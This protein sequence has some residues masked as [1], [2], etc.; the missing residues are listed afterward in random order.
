MVLHEFATNAV[1]YGALS[2]PEGFVRI[3]GQVVDGSLELKWEE[4]NGPHLSGSP[5]HEGFGGML[6][7]RIVKGQF[8]G[9][10][11]L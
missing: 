6:A 5:D 3:D 9:E 2:R 4:R 1:K 8:E 10:L 11:C 7:G